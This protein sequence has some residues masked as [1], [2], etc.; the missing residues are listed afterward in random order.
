MPALLEDKNKSGSAFF[1]LDPDVKRTSPALDVKASTSGQP[2]VTRWCTCSRFFILFRH[3]EDN[4]QKTGRV[5]CQV[6]DLGGLSG[7]LALGPRGQSGLPCGQVST[8]QARAQLE[9]PVK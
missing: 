3:F 6:R 2:L 1:L 4:N 8:G 7:K 5:P 9:W